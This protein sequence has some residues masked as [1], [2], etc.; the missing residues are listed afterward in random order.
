MWKYLETMSDCRGIESSLAPFVEGD[1]GACDRAHVETHLE[2]CPACRDLA[3][4]ERTAHELVRAR[5]HELR[6]TAP[7]RLRARCAAAAHPVPM[8]AV[9]STPPWLRFSMAATLVLA[10]GFVLLLGLGRGVESYAAQLAADH[11]KCFTFPPASPAADVASLGR[12]WQEANGW[13]LR[14]AAG[15]PDDP[16][17]LELVGLRRC[18]ST[19]GRVAHLLYRWRDAPLSVYVLNQQLPGLGDLQRRSFGYA[20]L[21]RLGEEEIIWSERGRTYAVVARASAADLQRVATH[22]R[23]RIE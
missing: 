21:K 20:H 3:D 7:D 10:G 5:R 13:P 1:E 19:R 12:S 8:P 16:E 2:A 22:V 6:G 15:G 18:G 17:G 4:A 23:W 9:R 11:V 14:I